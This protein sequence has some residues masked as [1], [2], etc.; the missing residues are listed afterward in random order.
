MVSLGYAIGPAVEASRES[1]G[2]RR[3]LWHCADVVVAAFWHAYAVA[4]INP[5]GAHINALR[6]LAH[7]FPMSGA[8]NVR[9]A[10]LIAFAAPIARRGA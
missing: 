9:D 7:A 8:A 3:C 10:L 6:S 1:E 4:Q 5:D 2:A